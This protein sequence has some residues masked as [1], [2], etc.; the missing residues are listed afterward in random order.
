MP[1][2][3]RQLAELVPSFEKL[4]RDEAA[5]MRPATGA[6]HPDTHEM[7]L[8]GKAEEWVNTIQ[9]T[10]SDKL[11]EVDRTLV[12]AAS[13]ITKHEGECKQILLEDPATEKVSSELAS[14][15][16]A[17]VRATER[18]LRA[19][20]AMQ[21]FQVHHNITTPASYP[22]HWGKVWLVCAIIW[23]VE[24]AMNSALYA[25]ENGLIGGAT[26]A[27]IVAGLNT[28]LAFGLGYWARYINMPHPWGRARGILCFLAFAI[29]TVFLNALFS[30][31]RS[32]FQAVLDPTDMAQT[33]HAFSAAVPLAFGIFK[34]HWIFSDFLSMVLFVAGLITSGIAFYKGY[35]ADDRFPGYG[36][37]DRAY[38]AARNEEERLQ[39][40]VRQIAKDMVIKL[41]ARVQAIILEP[42][43]QVGVLARRASDVQ[44]AQ[45]ERQAQMESVQRDY[46]QVLRAYRQQNSAVLSTSRPAYFTDYPSLDIPT[47]SQKA[48]DALA[49]IAAMTSSIRELDETYRDRLNA[50]QQELHQASVQIQGELIKRLLADIRTEAESSIDASIGFSAKLP[51]TLAQ[52]A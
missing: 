32:E 29:S 16:A 7:T 42:S 52:A 46:H 11:V 24:T 5:N 37:L 34:L 14:E 3:Q 13:L 39:A 9:T 50:K 18:R 17:I 27:A 22:D 2:Y 26:V 35:K 44:Q 21:Q 19:Q 4:G 47:A 31:F 6:L 25:N 43:N 49:R 23:A 15:R 45:T 40:V 1:T 12:E 28:G 10:F 41:R 51:Q 36:D 30:A 38:Q 33:R 20:T 48:E 8:R